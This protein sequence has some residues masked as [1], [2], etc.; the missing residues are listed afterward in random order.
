MSSDDERF[1]DPGDAASGWSSRFYFLL[2]LVIL[3]VVSAAVAVT[4]HERE[5]SLCDDIDAD[6]GSETTVDIEYVRCK[7]FDALGDPPASPDQVPRL[8]LADSRTQRVAQTLAVQMAER[9]YTV[10][11]ARARFNLSARLER[12]A[13]TDRPRALYLRTAFRRPTVEDGRSI[14]YRTN[15]ELV[16]GI[17]RRTFA[18]E[19][20]NR[21]RLPL[22]SSQY[23]IGVHVTHDGRVFVVQVF[24]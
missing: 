4:L 8:L 12:C 3:V 7:I 1:P 24:C 23:A 16:G 20:F 6:A 14:T 13:A 22:G 2:A 17:V 5:T 9:N 10:P 21:S 19:Y 15:D 18:T 11:E